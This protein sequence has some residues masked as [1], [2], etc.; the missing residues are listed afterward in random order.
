LRPRLLIW[1]LLTLAVVAGAV[2]LTITAGSAGQDDPPRAPKPAAA[3]STPPAA[4]VAAHIRGAEPGRQFGHGPSVTIYEVAPTGA[5]KSA[6]ATA[7]RLTIAGTFPCCVTWPT[8]P[9]AAQRVPRGG[10]GVHRLGDSGQF[11]C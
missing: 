7:V 8:G 10:C 11:G 2:T 9:G 6:G 5:A 3:R 4:P 1:A